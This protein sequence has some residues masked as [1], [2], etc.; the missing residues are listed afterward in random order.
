MKF[1][2]IASKFKLNDPPRNPF[3]MKID[4]FSKGTIIRNT[5]DVEADDE[6][7]VRR[8][9]DEWKHEP[10]MNG[11]TIDKI[12]PAAPIASELGSIEELGSDSAAPRD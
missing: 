7:H 6:S 2:V 8:L 4:A 9:W 12:L 11:F 3:L 5:Y 1:T 10:S